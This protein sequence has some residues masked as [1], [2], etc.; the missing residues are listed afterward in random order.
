MEDLI[1]NAHILFQSNSSPPLPPAPSG[2]P[3]PVLSYG[4]SHTKIADMAPPPELAP[5]PSPER[6]PR[7]SLDQPRAS[8]DAP[9]IYERAGSHSEDFTPQLPPRPANSIHPSLRAGAMSALPNRQSL[10]PPARKAQFF[11]D[12]INF[13]H[14]TS[15]PL[16]PP[17]PPQ[18]SAAGL[19][20]PSPSP[21][22]RLQRTPPASLPSLKSPW[23][24][25]QPSSVPGTPTNASS[26][27]INTSDAG[28]GQDIQVVSL[29]D[30]PTS[31]PP[32][33][34]SFATSI[35]RT[36]SISSSRGRR[37]PGTPPPSAANKQLALGESPSVSAI[38]TSTGY[39]QLGASSSSE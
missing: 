5:P 35:S 6:R 32:T 22:R 24:G 1:N 7:A 31:V 2:E 33:G 30:G 29:D 28:H 25:S 18:S 36:P 39:H 17:P 38:S 9:G 11:D 15:T 23:S 3:V 26:I 13:N 10:P 34:R 20:P 12:S 19:A 4:S 8:F 37:T 16:P 27:S 21:S 14:V